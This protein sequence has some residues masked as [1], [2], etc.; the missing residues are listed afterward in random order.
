MADEVRQWVMETAQ[1]QRR[2]IE[3]HRV[4]VLEARSDGFRLSEAGIDVA[5]GV[6]AEFVSAI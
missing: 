6:A 2:G 3:G 4:K 5:D 1:Q